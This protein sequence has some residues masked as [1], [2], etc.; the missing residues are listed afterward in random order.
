MTATLNNH[1]AQKSC[2]IRGMP[3]LSAR[4]PFDFFPAEAMRTLIYNPEGLGQL[5]GG[6]TAAVLE[7]TQ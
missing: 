3:F 4:S 1:L 7:Q 6:F 5:L 2:L